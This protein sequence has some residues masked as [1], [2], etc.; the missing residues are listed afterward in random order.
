M[1]LDSPNLDDRTFDELVAAAVDRIRRRDGAWRDLSVGD[2]GMVL[3]DAFAFVTEQLLFRVNRIPEKAYVA[4]LN[5]IGARLY[6]PTAATAVLTFTLQAPASAPVAIPR[7]TRVGAQRSGDT[8]DAPIVFATV[9][10][11]T[12][13]AGAVSAS[14]RAH[15]ADTYVDEPLGVGTGGG[16]QFFT[17]AHAPIVGTTGD[18]ADLLVA[19]ELQPE[20]ARDRVNAR[21]ID[22]V[23]YRVWDEVQSF[24]DADAARPAYVVDRASGTIAFAPRVRTSEAGALAGDPAFLAPVPAAG[25]RIRVSYATGGG[26]RG[27]VAP[28]TL[29]VLKDP[30]RDERRCR[31]GGPSRRNAG[32][33]ADSR[34]ARVPVAAARG[35]RARLRADRRDANRRRRAC[36]GVCEA[37]AV[38][39]CGARYGRGAARSG[40]PRSRRA[41]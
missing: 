15:N 13:P 31:D 38:E 22:G 34:S 17:V 14:V 24:A 8:S 36:E 4:F 2:P 9:D 33:R 5:L 3:L 1:P 21:V 26:I 25:A 12:I 40:V 16:S 20:E 30:V 32:E 10:D 18:A 28:G 6:P 27:N 7:G 29:T 23:A 37:R 41:R 19:V 11:A 35:H 39:L